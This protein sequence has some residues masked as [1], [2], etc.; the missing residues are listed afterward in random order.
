M[1]EQYSVW[2]VEY[3]WTHTHTHARAHAHARTH[4]HTHTTHVTCLSFMYVG[5]RRLG[6]RVLQ[7]NSIC[8]INQEC[9]GVLREETTATVLPPSTGEGSFTFGRCKVSQRSHWPS[10]LQCALRAQVGGANW[11]MVVMMMAYC[12]LN[13]FIYLNPRCPFHSLYSCACLCGCV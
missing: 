5:Y 11:K 1:L 12:R 10:F 13:S 8:Y 3:L 6:P 7:W 9:S 4:T 2:G